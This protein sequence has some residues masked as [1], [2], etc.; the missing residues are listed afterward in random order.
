MTDNI[1]STSDARTINNVMRHGYRVLSDAEKAQMQR[2]KDDGLAFWEYLDGIGSSRELS[3]AKT[4]IE[5]AVMWAVKH[6]TA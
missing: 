1:D 3:I 5:E 4:K 2:L 6:V